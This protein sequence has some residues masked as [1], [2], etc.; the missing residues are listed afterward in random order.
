M[1]RNMLSKVRAYLAHRRALGFKLQ[2]E[3]LRLLEFGRYADRRRHGGPLTTQLAVRWACL[4]KSADRLYH[5]RRL[6]IVRCFAKH[7][8]LTEPRTQVPPRHLLGPAH[9]RRSPHLY[10]PAQLEQLL[11]RAAKLTGRF[12]PQTW[13]TLI[14]LLACS[15]LRISEALQLRVDDVD[16]THSLL[17]IRESKCGKSRLVPLHR[18]AVAALQDYAQLRQKTFPPAEYFFVSEGGTRLARS[19]VGQTFDQLRKGIPYTRRPPRLHDLRHTMASE[20][21]WRWQ[22]SRKGAVNRILILSRFLG[23]SHVEDTYWYLTALPQMLAEAAQRFAIDERK[24]S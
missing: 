17:I 18:T 14:G 2:S 4:P 12:R 1:K 7:L 21:L 10:T 15:G 9:R 23:H 13:R 8:L 20:V 24:T 19:T 11:R 6:E 5:A 3:G 16:W 22:S